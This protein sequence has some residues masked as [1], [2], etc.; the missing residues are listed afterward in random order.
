MLNLKS[1]F[2]RPKLHDS[3]PVAFTEILQCRRSWVI[4]FSGDPALDWPLLALVNGWQTRFH[5]IQ[6]LVPDEYLEFV[7]AMPFQLHVRVESSAQDSDIPSGSL[8]L[9][10]DPVKPVLTPNG[11]AIL[12]SKSGANLQI[13]PGP[14]NGGEWRARLG[15]LLQLQVEAVQPIPKVRP[16]HRNMLIDNSFPHIL[17]HLQDKVKKPQ[18]LEA[19]TFLKQNFSANVYLEG[20]AKYRFDLPGFVEFESPDLMTRYA[21]ALACDLTVAD[22]SSILSGLPMRSICWSRFSPAA[23]ADPIRNAELAADLRSLLMQPS[24]R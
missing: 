1:L 2:G 4:R 6:L 3:E 7:K 15:E 13:T 23:L 9:D 17:I 10:L 19:I 11:C 16:D 18:V 12:S 21:F 24:G 14:S 20:A 22:P 5:R 8:V